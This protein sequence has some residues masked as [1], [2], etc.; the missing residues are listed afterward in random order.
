[1]TSA[2]GY[3]DSQ[4]GR[5]ESEWKVEGKKLTYKATV[6]AN[7]TATLYLPASS[8]KAITEGGKP[9]KGVNGIKFL[10]Y[11]NGKAVFELQSG[12]YQF[13]AE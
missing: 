13:I 3:Y 1:M 2:K 11:Q 7:T 10:N 4:Y 6:P 9:V 12:T 8:E 5:I